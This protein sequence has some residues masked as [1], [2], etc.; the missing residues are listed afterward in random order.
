M[1]MNKAIKYFYKKTNL[2]KISKK[3]KPDV[4]ITFV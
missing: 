4:Q 2:N 1:L 3:N